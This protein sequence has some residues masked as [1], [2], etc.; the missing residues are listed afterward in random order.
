MRNGNGR[1]V[2]H[3]YGEKLQGVPPHERDKYYNRTR[4][5]VPGRELGHR[6]T[7]PYVL[8]IVVLKQRGFHGGKGGGEY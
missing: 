4:E 3:Q 2:P 1:Y 5:G 6:F 7:E 8:G